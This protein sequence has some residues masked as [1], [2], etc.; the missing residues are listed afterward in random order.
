MPCR[1]GRL[2]VNSDWFIVEPVDTSGGP[3]PADR[4][5]DAVLVANLANHVQP[6]IRYQFG[7]GVVL[8]AEPC[9]CASA[10]T[11]IRVEG[12]TD[13]ILRVSRTGGGEV[14]LLPMAV[15]TVVEETLGVRRYQVLQT[16]PSTLTVRLET[17]PGADRTEVWLGVRA[18]LAAL[19]QAQHAA[20]VALQLA[21]EGP[22]ANP[23]SGKLRHVQSVLPGHA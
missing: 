7:D 16:A 11:T 18:Q 10:L 12:R 21:K 6:V 20:G 13:E 5:S 8:D 9:A 19:L 22:Q 3:V 1:K 15:A 4:R 17:D 23:R 14:V 2:H